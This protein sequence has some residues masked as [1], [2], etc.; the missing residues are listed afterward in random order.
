[1][2]SADIRP[3]SEE[4]IVEV[5]RND[6]DGDNK[7]YCQYKDLLLLF[8]DLPRQRDRHMERTIATLEVAVLFE[9]RLR[10]RIRQ[11]LCDC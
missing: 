9:V 6:D 7:E 11:N 2:D 1:M 8:L 10:N 3:L 5:T 4:H